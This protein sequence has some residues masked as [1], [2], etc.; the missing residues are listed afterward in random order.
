MYKR[1]IIIIIIIIVCFSKEEL[2]VSLCN[3]V[4]ILFITVYNTRPWGC[5]LS[6]AKPVSTSY[7]L[8][9]QNEDIC[10]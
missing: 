9:L 3:A 5:M 7:P 4:V 10:Q 8:C 1:I 2:L 6:V